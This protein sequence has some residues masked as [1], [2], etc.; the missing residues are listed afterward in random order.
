MPAAPRSTTSNRAAQWVVV[1]VAYAVLLL[2]VYHRVVFGGQSFAWDC[3]LEYWP[4]LVFQTEA[5]RSG[6]LPWWNPYSLSGYAFV[7][8]L[9][10]G[11]L[12]PVNWLCIGLGF[13]AGTGPWLISGESSRHDVG[14]RAEYACVRVSTHTTSRTCLRC[15]VYISFWQPA[16]GPQERRITLATYVRSAAAPR[17]ACI[18]D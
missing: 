1:A 10:S 13:V 5:L 15:R 7:G 17:R 16:F 6:E 14:G 18:G 12:S 9:Q 8:D 4:D 11:W 2:G 3:V